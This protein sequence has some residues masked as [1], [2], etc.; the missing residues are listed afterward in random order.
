L[1]L[2]ENLNNSFAYAGK[3]FKDL[4]R[5]LILIVLDVIPI[6]NW[7]VWG[8][9]GRVVSTTPESDEPPAL[10]K[11]GDLWVQGAKAFIV[12]LLYMLIP[13]AL[14]VFG[15][16]SM[17][18]G[19]IEVPSRMFLGFGFGVIGFGVIVIAILLIFFVMIVLSMALAHLF[20]TGQ[21]GRAFSLREIMSII[22]R[23][24]WGK[25]I[26]WL[27]II[28]IIVLVIG[29]IGSIPYI[30]WLI[31]LIIAPVV[32]V[33][34]ARSAALIYND[35]AKEP[36]SMPSRGPTVATAEQPSFCPNCGTRLAAGMNFC[37]NCGQ[38][39]Q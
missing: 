10:E 20:R 28:F 6:V 18:A 26:L 36:V 37:P 33:F 14:I 19:L 8:Y 35:G 29:G 7:I 2:G 25:Y 21:L 16:L 3:M 17:G 38:R 12:T 1:D 11:L 24:G 4:G 31:S 22:G 39:L 9:A 27:I 5:L 34:A 23:V 32:L 13:I 15:A 30:G